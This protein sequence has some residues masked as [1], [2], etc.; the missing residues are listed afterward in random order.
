MIFIIFLVGLINVI[1]FKNN[2]KKFVFYLLILFPYFGLIEFYLRDLSILYAI[3]FDFV[4]I[5]PI[6]FLYFFKKNK[7]SNFIELKKI[8]LLIVFYILLH[9][10]YIF[11]PN[12]PYPLIGRLIGFKIWTFYLFFIFI[13]YYFLETKEDFKKIINILSLGVII[14]CLILIIQYLIAL[15][16]GYEQAFFLIE[17][18]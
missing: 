18:Y 11:T 2:P 10:I 16:Y 7:N 4:F 9:I 6:Y 3:F 17:G 13:G 8:T 14:P 15:L 12:N 5:I 1:L